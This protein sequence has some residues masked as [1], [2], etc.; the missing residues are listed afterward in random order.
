MFMSFLET[1]SWPLV[2]SSVQIGGLYIILALLVLYSE[3]QGKVTEDHW[4]EQCRETVPSE[5]DSDAVIVL[6]S[7]SVMS[8]NISLLQKTLQFSPTVDSCSLEPG[9]LALVRLHHI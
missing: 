7:R 3:Q 9:E 6:T 2:K 8:Q 1:A 5:D 4:E